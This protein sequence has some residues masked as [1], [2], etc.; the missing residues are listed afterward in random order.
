MRR[1]SHLGLAATALTW[2]AAFGGVGAAEE[3]RRELSILYS[4]NNQGYVEPCG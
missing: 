4:V 2:W 1:H 3:E